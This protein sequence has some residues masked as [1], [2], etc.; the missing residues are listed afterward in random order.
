MV[1][2]RPSVNAHLARCGL[3]RFARRSRVSWPRWSK[4]FAL[5]ALPP[6]RQTAPWA[7]PAAPV[8]CGEVAAART[9]A[10]PATPHSRR[11]VAA[12]RRQAGR[13][14]ATRRQWPY[15]ERPP[16]C[17]DGSGMRSRLAP[18]R[19]PARRDGVAGV[20]RFHLWSRLWSGLWSLREDAMAARRRRSRA[21]WAASQVAA[22][23]R[24]AA[25][26][27][28]AAGRL[29]AAPVAAAGRLDAE[30]HSAGEGGG[31]AAVA[32]GEAGSRTGA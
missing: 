15:R 24:L 28:A 14:R 5:L 18:R 1:S 7:P 9:P 6:A 16:R 32:A 27:V 20:G 31:R 10:R 23:G 26:P 17:P 29:A 19:P 4:S 13:S 12:G 22:A 11:Q 8:G 2:G 25:A 30:R 3:R 21:R